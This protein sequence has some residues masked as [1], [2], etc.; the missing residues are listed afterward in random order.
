MKAG[1]L[2]IVIVSLLL[3][4]AAAPKAQSAGDPPVALFA[5]DDEL[6]IELRLP[7]KRLLRQ[8]SQD[9]EVEGVL[10]VTNA[11][12]ARPLDVE[13]R[14]RGHKR[15]EICPFPPLRLN[16]RRSQVADTVFAGQNRL[17]LVTLCADTERHA[18]YLEL[19]YLAYRM[20]E[21]VAEAAF[22][23]RWSNMRYVDSERDDEAR[24]A[25]AFFLEPIGGV[26]ERLALQA[27]AVPSLR[28]EQ[29]EPRALARLALFQFMIGN[30]DWA[31]TQPTLGEDACCHNGDVLARPAD[32]GS[33]V[34][35]PF[36]FDHA[37]IVGA[38]YAKPDE[39]LGIRSV[40]ERLYRGFCATNGYLDET[41]A[42]FNAARPA[43]EALLEERS[44]TPETRA[45]AASYLADSYEIL[46]DEHEKQRQIIDRCLRS[47]DR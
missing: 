28:L 29:L 36:D 31:V 24:T 42:A 21:Q 25:P 16:L 13:I 44:S 19:E 30:T 14:P 26:A 15:L 18:R 23:V 20:Y 35:V 22:R 45:A 40:R 11:A 32:P 12:A 9:V 2:A 5:S 1:C 38:D 7:L 17:K 37:G 39:R 34:I 6:E 47:S 3:G 10:L 8:R 4:V 33:F 46:N 27:V 41:I 43:I